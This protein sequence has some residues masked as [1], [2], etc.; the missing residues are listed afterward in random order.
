M[1]KSVVQCR[2]VP[3]EKVVIRS[4]CSPFFVKIPLSL[5]NA[6]VAEGG[7]EIE[8]LFCL[9]QVRGEGAKYPKMVVVNGWSQGQNSE[10]SI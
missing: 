9:L 1:T 2:N 7:G 6:Y 3:F 10:Q 5:G 4:K 8:N